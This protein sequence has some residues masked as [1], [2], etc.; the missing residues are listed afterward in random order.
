MGIK[1]V[2]LGFRERMECHPKGGF[3][4]DPEEHAVPRLWDHEGSCVGR[5]W[6]NPLHERCRLVQNSHCDKHLEN[7]LNLWVLLNYR[8]KFQ[9]NIKKK[10]SNPFSWDDSCSASACS[11]QS[12]A[13][14]GRKPSF[15]FLITCI[16]SSC[17]LPSPMPDSLPSGS[18]TYISRWGVCWLLYPGSPP[19]VFRDFNYVF[20]L[21][22][23]NLLNL[24]CFVCP[25]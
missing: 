15:F 10:K 8:L 2:L 6:W 16:T 14:C 17:P 25:L 4:P 1:S 24:V 11:F 12:V 13:W 20:A 3:L 9:C 5:L 18:A 23:H 21:F 22:S 7:Y 19:H